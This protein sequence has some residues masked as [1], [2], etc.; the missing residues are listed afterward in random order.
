MARQ[1]TA[2]IDTRSAKLE[3]LMA[4]ADKKIGELKRLSASSRGDRSERA[5][6]VSSHPITGPVAATAP[7]S[8]ARHAEVYTLADAGKSAQ[9]ISQKL[10]RP[11]GEIELILA[12]RQP[13]AS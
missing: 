13:A 10:N 11:R 3:A 2:Q 5:E 4:D 12:L 7:S 6:G 1:I 8:D 9:E